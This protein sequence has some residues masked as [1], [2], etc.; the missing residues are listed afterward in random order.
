MNTRNRTQAV[1]VISVAAELAGMHPQTLRIYE[2]RGLVNPARTQ[3]GNRRYSD[4]DIETLQRIAELAEQGMN[5]EGIRR[6]MELEYENAPPPRRAAQRADWPPSKPGRRRAPAAP[7]PRA[8]AP[9]RGGLRGAAAAASTR[10]DAGASESPGYVAEHDR[11]AV[12]R[13]IW[14]SSP[15]CSA[16][17]RRRRPTCRR[18]PGDRRH[19]PARHAVVRRRGNARA[20]LADGFSGQH[21]GAARRSRRTDRARCRPERERGRRA[22]P[23]RSATARTID[24]AGAAARATSVAECR[25]RPRRRRRCRPGGHRRLRP[26]VGSRPCCCHPTAT[27]CRSSSAPRPTRNDT[28]VTPDGAV[29]AFAAGAL[30]RI[31]TTADDVLE[32][33]LPNAEFTL[34]GATPLVL[35]GDRRRVRLGD[36]DWVTIPGRCADQRDRAAATGSERRLRLARR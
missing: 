34:V 18:I 6:V 3:G 9:G 31:T 5:L 28:L 26:A 10:D 21:A 27:R 32:T 4:A 15:R 13:A 23:S 7:R 12:A 30:H 35:D 29:M 8:L 25:H 22:R 14:R 1:Y 11:G 36:G 2:R 24:T 20:V 33:A 17:R 19:R 16:G